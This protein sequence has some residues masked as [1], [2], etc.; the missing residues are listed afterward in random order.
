MANDFDNDDLSWMRGQNSDDDDWSSEDDLPDFDWLKDD[1]SGSSSSRS[2]TGLTGQLPW[3]RDHDEAQANTPGDR[4]ERLGVTGELDWRR[5]A[6]QQDI[7][8]VFADFDTSPP[9]DDPADTSADDLTRDDDWTSAVSDWDTETDSARFASPTAADTSAQDVEDDSVDEMPDWLSGLVED[10]HA[11]LGDDQITA[12]PPAPQLDADLDD[13][14]SMFDFPDDEDAADD[15]VVKPDT[16]NLPDWLQGA[17]PSP[18]AM[19][20][21]ELDLDLL[22]EEPEDTDSAFSNLFDDMDFETDADALAFEDSPGPSSV[23]EVDAVEDADDYDLFAALSQSDGDSVDLDEI[24][25]PE[26]FSPDAIQG[27]DDYSLLGALDA[28]DGSG[29]RSTVSDNFFSD[30]LDDIEEDA[31]ADQPFE[32]DFDAVSPADDPAPA[33]SQRSNFAADDDD[34][35]DSLQWMSDLEALDD[36]GKSPVPSEELDGV[37]DFLASLGD[38]DSMPAASDQDLMVTGDDID[39]NRLLSD[40]AFADFEINPEDLADVPQQRT[41]S[42]RVPSPD[43]PDWLSDVSIREVSA[44]ALVRQQQDQPLENL[45]DR[46]QALREEGL[47]LPAAES[48]ELAPTVPGIDPAGPA[49]TPVEG[50]Q[51][52]L[53]SEQA[54]KVA[55]L[56]TVTGRD[57]SS[58][59]ITPDRGQR[60][61]VSATLFR[62]VGALLIAG[63]VIL[64][65]LTNFSIGNLPPSTFADGSSPQAVFTV[66][67]ELEP[68]E[69]VLFAAEYDGANA[70][71]LDGMADAL[72]RHT[73]LRGGV[74]V[75]VSTNPVGLLRMDKRLADISN[76][77][78]I[79]NEHYHIGQLIAGEEIGLRSLAQDIGT[80]TAADVTGSRTGLNVGSLNDF[81]AIVIINDEISSIRAWS[82]QVAP[83]TRA[84]LLFAT[85]M[86]VSPVAA[87]YAAAAGI[88]GLLIGYRDA[89]TYADQLNTLIDGGAQPPLIDFA[90]ATPTPEVTAPVATAEPTEEP[91]VA[92]TDDVTPETSPDITP[93]AEKTEGSE[94]SEPTATS[95]P[96][97]DEP[98]DGT[99]A[100]TATQTEPPTETPEPSPTPSPT[101]EIDATDD[102]IAPVFGTV[103]SDEPVNV[104]SGPGTEFAPIGVLQPGER[105]EVVGESADGAW[106]NVQL[107]NAT[108]GWVFAQLVRIESPTSWLPPQQVAMSVLDLGGLGMPNRRP[109][110]LQTRLTPSPTTQADEEADTDQEASAGADTSTA[111]DS[112][113][114]VL[115]LRVEIPYREERWYGTTLGILTIIVIIVIGNIISLLT[116]RAAQRAARRE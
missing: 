85:S 2:S 56:R 81:A 77:I 41:P 94:T 32:F 96:E 38:F 34:G 88:G 93:A 43:S 75:V 18:E 52:V 99:T 97:T 104:R 64:P 112:E 54:N 39:F 51:S 65:F 29:T 105:F 71:E 1:D 84:P 111:A 59:K 16:G 72:L 31:D 28:P 20:P 35:D 6:S 53:T 37:D 5:T 113:T 23:Y 50:G 76:G 79:R 47:H 78:L 95:T 98:D 17:A 30:L 70:A 89:Y 108:R 114:G 102:G 42:Q 116:R 58:V 92:V 100:P 110:L 82:E 55:I 12:S 69:L 62:L 13:L 26:I 11:A 49:P 74:P 61:P 15:E 33:A 115:N 4:S 73:I 27:F 67:D 48:V 106:V 109:V 60:S 87:P 91:E 8:S 10:D 14:G 21:D 90:T 22:S 7:E 63:A 46:L 24:G 83:L 19:Q 68:R 107:A 101:P 86:S 25:P 66:I 103:I 3:Q 40:P 36:L 45:P 57:D 44:S 80:L 9:A